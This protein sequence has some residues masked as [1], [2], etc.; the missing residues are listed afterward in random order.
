MSVESDVCL[1]E[2]AERL[3]VDAPPHKP[4]IVSRTE[5]GPIFAQIKLT[6]EHEVHVFGKGVGN[7]WNEDRTF[8]SDISDRR[9]A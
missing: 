1:R 9:H 2:L 7:G 8:V 4:A 3:E 6:V 5:L